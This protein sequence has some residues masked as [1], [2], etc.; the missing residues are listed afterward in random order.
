MKTVRCIG[1]LKLMI[2]NESQAINSAKILI[3]RISTEIAE[4]QTQRNVINLIESI[5]IYIKYG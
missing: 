3:E 1:V 4:P 5:I 2:Q